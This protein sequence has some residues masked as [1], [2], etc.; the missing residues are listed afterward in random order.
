MNDFDTP[1]APAPAPQPPPSNEAIARALEQTADL[2]EAKDANSFRIR[3]FRRAAQSILESRESIAELTLT[4][5]PA[6]LKRLPGIGEGLA[7]VIDAFVR[8]GG[9]HLVYRGVGEIAPLTLLMSLP[10]VGEVLARRILETLQVRDLED[11]EVAIYE[12]RLEQ[13]PGFGPRR[14]AALRQMMNSL[15]SRRLRQRSS[16]LS[17]RHLVGRP[18]LSL[19]LEVDEEYRRGAREGRLRTIA[20]RRFNPDHRP[21]LPILDTRKDGWTF[22][23]LF[24]NTAQAHALGKTGDWVVIFFGR[25]GESHQ[26]TVV[27]ETRGPL[28]GRRVVRGRESELRSG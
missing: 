14:T 7:G 9:E 16:D 8:S 4:V 11:L 12:G 10:G 18:P 25:A 26:C 21:W 27:T 17:E 19:L 6:A 20:P 22:R 24:S 1:P 15:L 13:V 5:G 2:L 3:A 23:A 28:T